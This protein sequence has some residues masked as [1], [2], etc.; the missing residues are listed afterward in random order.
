VGKI[1]VV[2]GKKKLGGNVRPVCGDIWLLGKEKTGKF[3]S[4]K[5]R[6]WKRKTLQLPWVEEQL[7]HPIDKINTN[8]LKRKCLLVKKR[9]VRG[10]MANV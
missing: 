3:P 4:G 5:S 10:E 9:G 7:R 2:R 1:C 8:L 6:D